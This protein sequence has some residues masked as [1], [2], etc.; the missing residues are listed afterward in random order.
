MIC[1]LELC[2]TSAG[3]FFKC[4]VG[5]AHNVIKSVFYARACAFNFM[6]VGGFSSGFSRLWFPLRF[7]FFPSFKGWTSVEGSSWVLQNSFW[8]RKNVVFGCVGL[9]RKMYSITNIWVGQNHPQHPGVAFSSLR[10]RC[11]FPLHILSSVFHFWRTSLS[12]ARNYLLSEQMLSVSSF[13][14]SQKTFSQDQSP[15]LWKWFHPRSRWKHLDQTRA[16]HRFA[17]LLQV[18]SDWRYK[19]T[20]WTSL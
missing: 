13:F 20:V 17:V 9:S 6:L 7:S 12:S 10:R 19:C 2:N 15:S 16:A 5:S 14:R 1:G 4:V 8:G 18:N 11:F 3:V